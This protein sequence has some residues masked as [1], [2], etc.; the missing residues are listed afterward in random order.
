MK[1][2]EDNISLLVSNHFPQFYKD[3]GSLFVDFVKEYYSWAQQSNNYLYFARNLLEYSDIDSTIDSFLVHFKEKYIAGS[4]LNL[5]K[6]K[7]DV[8]KAKDIYRSKGTERGTKLFISREFGIDQVNIYYPGKDVIKASDGEWTRSQY[9]ELTVTEKVKDFIG[10][11]ITGSISGSTAFVSSVARRNINGHVFDIVIINDLTG[12]FITGENVTTDGVVT[13]SPK[14]VGSLTS[15]DLLDSGKSFAK[16]DILD[17]VSSRK[18]ISGKARVNSIS[19]SGGEASFFIYDGG[20]G[21]TSTANVIV[22]SKTIQIGSYTSSNTYANSFIDEEIISQPM[23][24]ISFITSNT[25]FSRGDWVTSSN[26]S[27]NTGSGIVLGASP[28]GTTGTMLVMVYEGSFTSP[29]PTK[30]IR[31]KF[32]NAQTA[33]DANFITIN[34][35]YF[36]TNQQ[37]QYI[38]ATGNT[39]LTGLT[40]NTSYYVIS[41]NSSGIKLS[42]TLGGSVIPL[43]SGLSEIGHILTLSTNPGALFSSVTDK[44]A[45]GRLIASNTE[46][47]GLA[48]V[49]NAFNQNDYN[50]I[51]GSKT[52]VKSTIVDVGIGSSA[53]FSIGFIT[54]STVANLNTDSIGS[55]NSINSPYMSL[56]INAAEYKFPKLATANLATVLN[57]AL[58]NSSFSIGTILSL[59]SINPGQGYNIAPLI[60][61]KDPKISGSF[62]TNL[63]LMITGISGGFHVGEDIVQSTT[64]A[65]GRVDFISDDFTYIIIKQKSVK[66][67]SRTNSI[68]GV[69]TSATATVTAIN[70]IDRSSYYG[71]NANVVASV[72][73]GAITSIEVVGSGFAYQDGEPV[74]LSSSNNTFDATGTVN[75]QKQGVSNGYFKTTRGFLNS[76]KYI[77]DGDFYQNYSYQVQSSIPL[78]VYAD[79]LKELMHVAGTKLFGSVIRSRSSNTNL[80]LVQSLI[81]IA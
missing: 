40:N 53:S 12:D 80:Q 36:E 30:F 70:Q 5:S 56:N 72:V 8:K 29:T 2:I 9:L 55:N 77:H 76:D 63:Q 43:T 61:V 66:N 74:T 16:G 62:K 22:A 13:D 54:D 33:V 41:A 23:A 4:P 64:S 69:D 44:T 47:I 3:E 24:N 65:V 42:L 48:N 46:Y 19:S 71:Y 31:S 1:N 21:Y 45:T 27:A 11:Q 52:G 18:G 67:F 6:I 51:T 14:I 79:V 81:T 38:T 25:T 32:F 17:V 26:S 28:V 37:V 39:S 57:S 73:S 15:I 68:T 35:N 10:K 20:F 59:S 75:L 49:T 60:Q 7:L 34:S 78:N 50:F 58:A